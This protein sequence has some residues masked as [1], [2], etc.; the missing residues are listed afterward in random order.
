MEGGSN[1]ILHKYEAIKDVV[2]AIL[3]KNALGKLYAELNWLVVS[4]MYI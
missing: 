1:D 3:H 2:S 4:V